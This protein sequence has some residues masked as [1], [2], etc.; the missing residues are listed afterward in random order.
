VLLSR[1]ATGYTRGNSG[2]ENVASGA[3]L[4]TMLT[5][6]FY[7]LIG[8]SCPNLSGNYVL[9]GEDGRVR[10]K[11]QQVGCERIT[12]SRI[13]SSFSGSSSE[14]HRLNLSRAVQADSGWFGGKDRNRVK[15]RFVGPELVLQISFSSAPNS[16]AMY[17]FRLMRNNDIC[18]HIVTRFTDS[19]YISARLL[20][21]N[22][23]AE[24]VA[25]NRSMP[26]KACS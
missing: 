20:K 13:A 11:I 22:R 6:L 8:I 15:A 19:Y 26:V 21:D 24:D 5:F 2:N 9:Q 18:T 4:T 7:T 1:S 23:A 12:I 10:V 3:V 16:I 25:A 14:T 17:S